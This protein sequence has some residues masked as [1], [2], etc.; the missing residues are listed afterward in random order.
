MSKKKRGQEL[1]K[2]SAQ[3][4]N[5]SVTMDG[6]SRFIQCTKNCLQFGTNRKI[7]EFNSIHNFLTRTKTYI[8]G[9]NKFHE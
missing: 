1:Q 4:L 5:I 7:H 6:K 8:L 3:S 2:L 9:V